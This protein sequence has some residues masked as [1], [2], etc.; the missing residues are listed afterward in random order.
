MQKSFI[1]DLIFVVKKFGMI[2]FIT[3]KSIQ[4]HQS[5]ET[6]LK[7]YLLVEPAILLATLVARPR[8]VLLREHSLVVVADHK[9]EGQVVPANH[10][11]SQGLE[12]EKEMRLDL[13]PLKGHL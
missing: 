4:K 1:F 13:V 2:D 6:D 8:G 9:E 11:C 5:C 7:V 12:R 3:E 10:H